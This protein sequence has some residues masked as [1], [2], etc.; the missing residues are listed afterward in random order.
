M[1]IK[2]TMRYHFT[3]VRTAI[4]KKNQAI[5]SF[6]GDAEEREPLYTALF[7]G[8]QIDAVTMKEYGGLSKI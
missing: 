5:I 8:T 7:V 1:Q 4:I 2:T 3:Y 6:G